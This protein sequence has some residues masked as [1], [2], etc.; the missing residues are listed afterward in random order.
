MYIQK[1][2]IHM[3]V[4]FLSKICSLHISK[5][6]NMHPDIGRI[7]K[8]CVKYKNNV[9]YYVGSDEKFTLILSLSKMAYNNI[10]EFP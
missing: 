1:R 10:N 7:Q 8:L 9:G 5:N 6:I 3:S 4:H 2:K